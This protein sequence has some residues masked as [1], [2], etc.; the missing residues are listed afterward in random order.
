MATATATNA[1]LISEV[2]RIVLTRVA[3]GKL[4]LPTMPAVATKCLEIIRNPD[5]NFK[6]LVEPV[7][8]EPLLATMLL[9]AAS[10]AANGNSVSSVD[11]AIS[12]LG[13]ARL[14]TLLLEYASHA[15]FKST[16]KRIAAASK[17]IWDHS[18]VV[19]YLSR[20][21]AALTGNSDGDACYLAG[22]LHDIGKPV[23]AAMLLDAE[24]NLARGAPSWLDLDVWTSTIETTHRKVGVA[25]ATEWKLPEEITAGIRDCSDYDS[26]NRGAVCNMVRLANALAKREGYTTGPIDADDVDAMI[27]VGRSLLG[28]DEDII[29]RLATS[30]KTRLA[31]A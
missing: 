17:A 26:A 28:A 24:K 16:D 27:M 13:A 12:R 6:R 15:V 10:S 7:E 2:E 5:F 30:L 25:I 19:A 3:A 14:K 20:D 22:L 18:V 21:I 11:R 23:V 29:T 1:R 31:S 4:V 8:S 9:R